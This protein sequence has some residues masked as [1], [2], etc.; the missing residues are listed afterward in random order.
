PDTAQVEVFS[1]LIPPPLHCTRQSHVPPPRPPRLG[2]ARRCRG[3]PGGRRHFSSTAGVGANSSG[4]SARRAIHAAAIGCAWPLP[5]GGPASKWTGAVRGIFF[6]HRSLPFVIAGQ[7]LPLGTPSGG[8]RRRGFPVDMR[9]ELDTLEPHD[10]YRLP[11]SGS[12]LEG[13]AAEAWMAIVRGLAHGLGIP[14]DGLNVR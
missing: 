13:Q 10:S 4:K 1:A 11:S 3:A 12:R 6:G 9:G 8:G 7:W 2:P 5:W 14:I